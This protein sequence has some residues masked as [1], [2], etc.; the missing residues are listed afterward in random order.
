MGDA[1]SP[2]L[3]ERARRLDG[4]IMCPQCAGQ[5]IDQSTS[6]VAR[7]M[8]AAIRR[9]LAAGASDDEIVAMLVAA[10]GEGVLASPPTRGFSLAAWVVPPAALLAGA[11]AVALAVRGLRR[12]AATAD[13]AP[14]DA[15]AD[16]ELQPYLDVVDRELAGDAPE[17]GRDG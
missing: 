9:E 15:G 7:T 2:E 17:G 16:G 5:T 12:R 6:P 8:K 13:A 11:V 1:L 14:Q 4:A 10:Y 3:E